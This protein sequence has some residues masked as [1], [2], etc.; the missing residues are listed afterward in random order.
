MKGNRALS[1]ASVVLFSIGIFFG[2]IVTTV[3]VWGDLEASLF[4]PSFSEEHALTS[5]SCPILLTAEEVGSV[6]AK[7][8]NPLD[9]PS[10]RFIRVHISHGYVT[11]MREIRERFTVLPGDTHELKW[12]VTPEDA[13]FERLILLKAHLS[14]RYPLPARISSCGI[15]VL[16][17]H[18]VTG[19]AIV[20]GSII[21]SALSMGLGIL[22][23]NLGGQRPRWGK[24][25]IA[26]SL[27]ILAATLLLGMFFA[28]KGWW[29]LGLAFLVIIL[30]M[31][32]GMVVHY[33]T[34]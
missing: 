27:I 28:F 25:S 15:M 18:G 6:T 7:V 34:S 20:T 12:S 33:I 21:A 31:M 9:R 23:W 5:L 11:L 24:I 3:A 19:S 14:A 29:V 4:D 8:H 32:L 22:L 10:D 17:I 16:N 2:G 26:R 1:A 13:A 30:L